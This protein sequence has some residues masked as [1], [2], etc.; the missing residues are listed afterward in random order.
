MNKKSA[1]P[2]YQQMCDDIR[3]KIEKGELKEN[4]KLM[5]EQEFSLQYNV[6]R[7]TVRKAIEILSDEGLV[8]KKQGIGTFVAAK[9]LSRVMDRIL[10]FSEMCEKNE[11]KP[12][13]VLVSVEWMKAVPT[14][15][16]ELKIP[17]GEKILHLCR[18][19]KCDNIPVM[20]EHC[21]LPEKYNY[22]L[23]SN[24]TGS[25]YEVFRENGVLPSHA[26]KTVEICYA[27]AM[28]AENLEVEEGTALLLHKD[29][30]SDQNGDVIHH[31]KLIINP[32]RY[33]LTFVM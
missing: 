17:E 9:K 1:I 21:Y 18:L 13:T 12:S 16:K 8:V 25:I 11:M 23:S 14:I 26:I 2:L 27:N 6:S 15:A 24:L 28:E 30:V 22:L 31:S 33:K 5:T 10:S 19:R 29:T 3:Y 20:L 4:D 32:D 7:I